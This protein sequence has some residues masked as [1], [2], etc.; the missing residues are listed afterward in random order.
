MELINIHAEIANHCGDI[1]DLFKPGV[2]VT[3]LVRNTKI[4][5]AD[6]LVTDDE[7]DLMIA[8]LLKLKQKEEQKLSSA[9]V[10]ANA[11]GIRL[12]DARSSDLKEGKL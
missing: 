1:S 11:I 10:L 5:D 8:A 4:T 12:P 6:V 3:V 7:I 2:K 9:D